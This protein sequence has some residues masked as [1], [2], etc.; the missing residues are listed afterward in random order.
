MASILVIEDTADIRDI[1]TRQLR[2]AGHQVTSA[3]NGI[4]GI[5]CARAQL[6]DLIV[7]D[8]V[9]PLLNGWEAIK[10]LKADQ[11]C[12]DLPIIAITA[13]ALVEIREQARTAGCD[14]FISKP[15]TML[16]LLTAVDAL[17]GLAEETV[18]KC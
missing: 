5:A 11:R 17:T 8:L 12:A 6:P 16:E 2:F 7:M 18:G 9:M 4:D 1:L 14:A 3:E 15:F 13:R 10:Q